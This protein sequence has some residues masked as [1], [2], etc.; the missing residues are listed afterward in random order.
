MSEMVMM[1]KSDAQAI[2]DKVREKTGV[3]GLLKS[4]EIAPLIDTITG[5]GGSEAKEIIPETDFSFVEAGGG[6]YAYTVENTYQ[7][8]EG[9]TYKVLWD[10]EEYEFVW[11]LYTVTVLDGQVIPIGHAL[12]NPYFFNIYSGGATNFENTGDPFMIGIASDNT[13]AILTNETETTHTVAVYEGSTGGNSDDVRYVTFM[14]EDGSTELLV[15]P[16]A[17]GDDCADVIARG[18]ISKPTKESTSQYNY[19]F[20]GWALSA[21][22]TADANALKS[23]TEDRTVYVAFKAVLRYYTI[24]YYDGDSLLNSES[25]AYGSMP[26]YEAEK[27]G[28]TLSGWLPELSTVTGNVDYYAQWQ[29]GLTFANVSL[30]RLVEIAN[31]KEGAN[32]FKVGD[33]K[34]VSNG[35]YELELMIIGFNHDDLA[36]GTGKANMTLTMTKR[37]P[38]MFTTPWH[39]GFYYYDSSKLRTAYNEQGIECL[40]STLAGAI[41][42]VIKKIDGNH[43]AGEAHVIKDSIE[44]IFALSVTEMNLSVNSSH[45]AEL[46]TPYE[47]YVSK[48]ISLKF[49]DE[50]DLNYQKYWTRQL[51]KTST[52]SGVVAYISNGLISTASGSTGTAG[53]QVPKYSKLS[54]CI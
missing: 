18:L 31:A 4:G 36:D 47:A 14:S 23:V 17:V 21:G 34:T 44:S 16:V 32:Y 50:T 10:G 52:M 27:E 13:F 35:T 42:P 6:I 20:N 41:K 53:L 37:C 15:K 45:Y 49:V 40:P 7:L 51:S 2:W 48:L 29:E 43:K 5:G 9:K 39:S 28:Y 33:V 3:S 54:F 11:N 1:P 25:L 26:S 12:G 24:N 30:E 38:D 22:G 19:T 8:E 46:G